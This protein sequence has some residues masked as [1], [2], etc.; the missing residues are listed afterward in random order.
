MAKRSGDGFLSCFADMLKVIVYDESA[1]G[2]VRSQALWTIGEYCVCSSKLSRDIWAGRRLELATGSET[3]NF[4]TRS[5]K[6]AR[7]PMTEER[8]QHNMPPNAVRCTASDT[9]ISMKVD[10]NMSDQGTFVR[11]FASDQKSG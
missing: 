11:V 1:P 3:Q 7:E 4:S 5:T 9:K 8:F 2:L 6:G 10:W